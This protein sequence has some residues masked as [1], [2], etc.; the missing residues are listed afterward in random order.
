MRGSTPSAGSV[1]IGTVMAF[2]QFNEMFWR[3]IRD[4]SEKY[5]IM[6]TAMA[7]SERVF[8]LLDDSTMVPDPG[9]PVRFPAVRGDI[10]FRNVWF[11][12]NP[13]CDG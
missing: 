4:L 3:P 8:K 2:L 12:Y 13:A 10:E 1:T 6:Q 11:A 7:S 9:H 5:N